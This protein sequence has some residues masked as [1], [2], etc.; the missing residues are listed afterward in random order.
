M[1]VDRHFLFSVSLA[2]LAS[3]GAGAVLCVTGCSSSSGFFQ[4]KNPFQDETQAVS[5]W[6]EK[7]K[8]PPEEREQPEDRNWFGP[9]AEEEQAPSPYFGR[10]EFATRALDAEPSGGKPNR[11]ERPSRQE[12][13]PA[14][15]EP[16]PAP[17]VSSPPPPT[18]PANSAPPVRPGEGRPC[19][20][21]NG[22][23]YRLDGLQAGAEFVTCDACQGSGRR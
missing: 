18:P 1:L 15:P 4:V 7:R 19:Y 12:S 21:C 9:D 17:M 23:G 14:T 13:A 6:M 8:L 16:G 11:S 2:R 5:T 3:I 10:G 20:R 22:K